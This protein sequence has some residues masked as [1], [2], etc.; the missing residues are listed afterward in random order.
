MVT[1][2]SYDRAKGIL[3]QPTI[4]ELP[5]L[6]E[7]EKVD[8]WVDLEDPDEKEQTILRDVFGFHELAIEDCI[9]S[10]IEEPKLD[11]YEDYLFMVL[12][13]LY[14][15]REDFLF[16][17]RQLDLF[18]GRNYVVTYHPK[19]TFGINRLKHALESSI[20]FMG[21]GT[22]EIFHAIIDSLVDNYGI[23]F[24]QIERTIYSIETEILSN[25]SER[26]FSNLFKLKIGLIN[27]RRILTPAEDVMKTLG[28]TE[29]ELIQEENKIYFQDVH[30]HISSING[31]LDSYMEMVTSTMNN[32]VSITTYRMTSAL[33]TFT[34][35]TL[36]FLLPTLITSLFSMNVGLPLQGISPPESGN[37][38]GFL[39]VLGLNVIFIGLM[40][41][42]F[43]K[44]DWL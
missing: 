5:E 21:R 6:L 18:F 34:L 39:F 38:V 7:A 17:I 43:K 30:D 24:K 12:H 32:Y 16:D 20:D 19:P 15:K 37:H 28:E 29:H 42:Y 13:P 2:Y 11:D 27:L 3:G 40:L 10:Q 8:L 31:L 33:K 41:W 14:F 25:P 1:I 26:T 4:G 22:D 36:C 23:I 35:L 9:Q 44:K